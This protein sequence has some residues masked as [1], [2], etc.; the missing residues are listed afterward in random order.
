MGAGKTTIA[1]LLSPDFIDMDDVIVER[2]G[3][4]ISTFFEIAGETAFREI[5]SQV[6]LELTQTSGV[7]STGGGVVMSEENRR[8]LSKSKAEVIYLKS[9]FD[10]LYQRIT[11]DKSNV[12]PLFLNNSRVELQAIFEA[13]APLYEAIATQIITISGKSPEAILK[14]IQA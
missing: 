3:M 5:E 2:I 1:N 13:R 11:A 7:I 14:E 8:I 9:D 4:P 10:T 12:R 6:L